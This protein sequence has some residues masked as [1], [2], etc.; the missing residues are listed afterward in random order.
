FLQLRFVLDTFGFNRLPRTRQPR[1][2]LFF[3]RAARS[4]F[5]DLV[6]LLVQREHFF[7]E[8]RWDFRS[9]KAFALRSGL[10]RAAGR[11]PLDLQQILEARNRVLE[12]SVR[13][14]QVRRS[15]ETLPPLG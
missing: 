5:P 15:R 4:Q 1:L 8:A 7:E 9:A 13:V 14:V 11:E 12:R 6:E 2:P 3:R 10:L